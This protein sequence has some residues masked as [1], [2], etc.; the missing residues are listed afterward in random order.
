MRILF[1]FLFICFLLVA[2][3]KENFD[4]KTFIVADHKGGF[5]TWTGQ[6]VSSLLIKEKPNESFRALGQEIEGFN[7]EQGFEYVIKVKEYTLDPV[8][9]DALNKRYVLNQ[10]ISKQ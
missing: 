10:I 2:C 9:A 7:Y 4:T 3:K 5:I 6:P 8:P 1:S